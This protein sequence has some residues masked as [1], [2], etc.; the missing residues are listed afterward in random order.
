MKKEKVKKDKVKKE[1]RTVIDKEKRKALLKK[2]IMVFVGCIVYSV[3]IGLFL[4]PHKMAAGG[5]TGISIIVN[6]AT[7]GIIGTGW[8][9]FIINVPLFIIGLIFFGKNFFVSSLVVTAI[10]SSF[11]ELLQYTVVPY[12]PQV[13]P[14][15]AA[16]AGGALYGIGVGLVFR[17]G[18]STG[19]TDI[20]VK[21][22][23]RKFRY[24][25]TGFISMAIDFLIVLSGA[26]VYRDI[27][28]MLLTVLSIVVFSVMFNR[29]LYGGNSAM[30]V[31]II[32]TAE[33]ARPICDGILKDLD[34]GATIIDGK[35]AYSGDEKVIIMCAIKNYAY[36]KLRD[37]VKQHDTGAFTIVSS[38]MEIYGEGYKPQDAEEL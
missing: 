27:E 5:V 33:R 15:V 37:V 1:K 20:I 17:T 13:D 21:L 29:A 18:S 3:G 14:M 19:G 6:Y 26:L 28:L 22:V 4:D 2:S 32:T 30:I 12:M 34:V 36:P 16:L 35:G 10:S 23:R 8:I 11:I 25:K 7:N 31:H 9:I 24:I 38:A